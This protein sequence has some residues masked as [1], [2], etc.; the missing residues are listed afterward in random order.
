MYIHTRENKLGIET[1]QKKLLHHSIFCCSNMNDTLMAG[2]PHHPDSIFGYRVSQ[3][4][5]DIMDY[6]CRAERVRSK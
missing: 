6:V 4:L 1:K 5:E 2:W 3:E